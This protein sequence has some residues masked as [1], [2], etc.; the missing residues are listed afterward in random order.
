MYLGGNGIDCEVEFLDG[1]A[2][3][4]CKTWQPRPAESIVTTDLDTG[5]AYDCR[6]HL[7]TG[8]SPAELLGVVFSDTGNATSAPFRAVDASHWALAGTGL[9]EGD[10]FGTTSLHERC[11]HGASGHETDK[12]T[13]RS[14]ANARVLAHGMN[15][16]NG[17]AEMVYFETGGRGAVFSVGSI[18]WPACMPVDPHVSRITRN[19]LER[20]LKE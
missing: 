15:D 19:A 1:G 9:R 17:G 10:V 14:P 6:F 13:P 12:R 18:T 20:F 16:D 8:R 3:M 7:S 11:P 4:R 2:A 5:R